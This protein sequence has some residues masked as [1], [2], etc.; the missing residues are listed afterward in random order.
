VWKT[1]RN[2]A[3]KIMLTGASG[4]LGRELIKQAKFEFVQVN[5]GDWNDLDKKLAC[6]VDTVIHAASDLRTR[7]SVSPFSLLDS[8]LLSTAK[9]L[10][11]V[12]KQSIPRF[13]F[14][15][16]C[17]VYGEGMRT[18]ES[19]RCCPVNINGI[20]KLLNEKIIEEFC[21]TNGIKF[22]ILRVFN[23]YGGQDNFSILSHIKKSIENNLPFNMN[24]QG[25]AQRDFV[26][27]TDVAGI[28]LFLLE[29]GMPFNHLN[30]GTGF[31]TKISTLVDLV[32]QR[33]PDFKIEHRNIDEAEYSRA[34]TA[35][36]SSLI[37]WKFVRI[38]DY[39]RN[40]FMLGK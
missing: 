29:K 28:I 38:E 9:L 12:R 36:L 31:A 39:M 22:E 6:G 30:I 15:S 16:S 5:R 11:E 35:K 34:D 24:N 37:S 32:M 17:S 18:N 3:M 19:S 23:L 14:I 1:G 33:F 7:A 8:N 40:E 4:N 27:V 2:I 20:G 10:E 25:V 26:H 13:I 21:Q